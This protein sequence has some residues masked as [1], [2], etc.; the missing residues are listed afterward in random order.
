MDYIQ[1]KRLPKNGVYRI[2]GYYNIAMQN[3]LMVLSKW[4]ILG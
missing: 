1:Q 3:E 4:E 2:D